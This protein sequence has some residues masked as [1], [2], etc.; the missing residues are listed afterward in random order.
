MDRRAADTYM[1]FRTLSTPDC[2]V[3]LSIKPPFA[4]FTDMVFGG[5]SVMDIIWTRLASLSHAVGEGTWAGLDWWKPLNSLLCG[6]LLVRVTQAA[7]TLKMQGLSAPKRWVQPQGRQVSWKDLPESIQ[8]T[9]L[10]G[11]LKTQTTKIWWWSKS[12]CTFRTNIYH[13]EGSMKP[14]FWY[15]VYVVLV[16]AVFQ[17]I[18]VPCSLTHF[19]GPASFPCACSCHMCFC[20]FHYLCPHDQ[21]PWLSL[22]G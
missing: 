22:A 19:M 15:L 21:W 7:W 2:T 20:S 4:E 13:T 11:P 1:G 12:R 6:P 16:S 9:F 5:P 10:P 3:F 17:R 8:V 18:H 14:L